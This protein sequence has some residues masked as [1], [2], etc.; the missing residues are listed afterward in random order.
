[1]GKKMCIYVHITHKYTDVKK[2]NLTCFIHFPREI[3]RKEAML[4]EI[5][6]EKFSE[7]TKNIKYA[8]FVSSENYRQ[9]SFK[10]IHM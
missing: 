7:M 8:T 4:E 3:R 10:E 6:V 9:N 1:M 2:K 5:I